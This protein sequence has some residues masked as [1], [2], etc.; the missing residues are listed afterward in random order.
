MNDK[1]RPNS[2][3]SVKGL[4]Y[5]LLFCLLYCT[6]TPGHCTA[7][8]E[9]GPTPRKIIA[10]VPADFP[11]TY[12][13]DETTGLAAGFSV[14]VMNEVA[15]RSGF[16]VEYIFAESWDMLEQAVLS[17]K[18]D[19]VPNL[20]IDEK[21]LKSMI[22]TVPVET[23][24]ISLIAR[25]SE[26]AHNSIEAG[27]K[28]GV[29]KGSS[30]D[31]FLSQRV[32]ITRHPYPGLQQLLLDLLAG[33][34]D[35]AMTAAPNILKM[36]R[37]A[38][39]EERIRIIEPCEYEAKRGMA[40]RPGNE[41]LRDRL[42]TV[43]EKFVPS[44][45]YQMLYQKWWGK[46]APFWNTRRVVW[47]MTGVIALL[48]MSFLYWHFREAGQAEKVLRESESRYRVLVDL[49][50]EGILLGS[51][52]GIITEANACM[53]A[54]VG[55]AREEFVG[56]HIR[57][58]P[59]EQ[60]NLNRN[61]LRFDLLQKGD[62]V[63]SERVL[64][65]PDGSQ[66]AVEM[67]TKMM[68]DGTYQSIYHDITERKL[69]EAALRESE[70]Q[71]RALSEATFEAIFLS[72]KGICMGQNMTAEKMFGYTLSEAA[73]RPGTEWIVPEDRQKVMDNMLSGYEAPYEV[74]ALRK[75]G[76]TFP[77]EIQG[78]MMHYRGR[79]V[80]V[81]AL[82]D[83]TE[84]KL[85]E[86]ALRESEETFRAM[87]ETFPLA[88]HLSVGIE[89]ISEYLNPKFIELFGYTL[90]DMPTIAQWWPLAYPDE[91]YREQISKEWTTRIKRAIETQSSIEPMEVVVTCKDG[92]K[93]NISWSF[94]TLGSKNYSCGFDLTARKQAE[95]ELQKMHKLQS[96]GTLAGGIAHDFNN[97][98]MGLYGNI[99]L[100]KGALSEYHPGFKSLSAAEKSMNRA[101]R[102]TKQLLTFA[103]GG[104]PVKEDVSIGALVEE[105]ARFD[106]S[107]SNVM[108]VHQQVEDLWPATVDKGQM[109]QVISNLT[110]N[111][112]Q[113][114]PN[115]GRVYIT[116]E[117]AD[118]TATVIPGL[119]QGKYIR[120][121][122][123][124]E[125][126]GV[127]QKHL[128]RIFDPYF[129]TKQTGSGL[130]LAT[131]YSI[132]HKHGGHI[133]VDSELGK[134]TTFTLYLPASKSPQRTEARKSAAE[135]PALEQTGRVLVMDDDETVRDLATQMLNIIGLSVETAPDGKQAIEMYKHAMEAGKPY[136]V[137]IMD[138]TVPGGIGGKEAIK[139]LLG[140]DPDARA[141]VSSGY[142]DDPVMAN[143]ADY[144]FKGI[145]AKPYTLRMLQEVLGQ[146]L[147]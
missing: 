118:I 24:K 4:A 93:K 2:A 126:T 5:F 136:A 140:I 91:T 18:A 133:G 86:A 1:H 63:A 60:E 84:H 113:A 124:D 132:I 115:G 143:Y 129:T 38:G 98:L 131:T 135:S 10:A 14:D 47:T 81:T 64:I 57:S 69:A 51:H 45:E 55:M 36:A 121:S 61:P 68:P 138:L 142:A 27:M 104:A 9:T 59:F 79:M 101:I 103:K 35:L 34:V 54:I 33:R 90:E 89:Q 108:L 97:I 7:E 65:R 46:P 71:F 48:V 75:D 120:I 19:L 40:L 62:I 42:N 52:E 117:N 74:I 94:I 77:A 96:V 15:R 67:R 145:A 116:M 39:I 76:G 105:V 125:G 87:V 21:R 70:E 130:G 22:F 92:S 146:V 109:Q 58:L 8:K 111:A 11:P 66:V 127:D 6:A 139:G 80:R 82:R 119:S 12:F 107:G 147:K 114:M 99:S 83:I 41:A 100:A 72:E 95:A 26:T 137:V 3:Q 122:V 144:G 32:D 110:I 30:V 25:A 106:L 102:L 141:I 112:C 134:G 20:T 53:C 23:L 85:A 78:K 123:R 29:M 128:D 31:H 16:V 50:V 43:I 17:E 37:D 28:I 13:R 56:K 88:I 44:L 73:G 49:A